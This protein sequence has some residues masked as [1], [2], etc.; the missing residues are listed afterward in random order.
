LSEA[1]NQASLL[2]VS[3]LRGRGVRLESLRLARGECIAVQGPSGAGKSRLLRA[4]ADLDPCDGEIRLNGRSWRE[5]AAPV[6]RRLVG[7]VPAEAGWWS[8]RVTDHFED[9]SSM[10]AT[11][12]ELG[13]PGKCLDTPVPRLS[14][15][16]RQR[17]ALA[18]ALEREPRV[19][20]LDEP[21]SALDPDSRNAV[22]TLLRRCLERGTAMLLVT[23]DDELAGRLTHRCL[24]VREGQAREEALP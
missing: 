14:T 18:R 23:H 11:I 6:W 22:E 8:E 16:E 21:T 7:Y 3:G 17:L 4:I 5:Q 1:E 10:Q 19:L 12:A 24:L 15:G 2:T 13:L 9:A 20:L